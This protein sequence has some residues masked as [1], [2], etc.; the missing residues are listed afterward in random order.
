MYKVEEKMVRKIDSYYF[1][2]P[3]LYCNFICFA[4]IIALIE[5]QQFMNINMTA[6]ET[7]E[8]CLAI[9]RDQ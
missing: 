3:A 1:E 2:Y 9:V 6:A 7:Y 8:K 5:Y 4:T